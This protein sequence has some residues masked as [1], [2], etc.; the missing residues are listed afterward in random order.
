MR[1]TR[2]FLTLLIAAA[3]SPALRA[4]YVVLKSGQRLSVTGYQLL[5]DR[6][7]LQV[8]GGVVEVPAESVLRFR[9]ERQ[10]V[11]RVTS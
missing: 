2:I 5:G 6:Y 7:R 11:L 9:L 1:L 3:A 4:E 8:N 10:L